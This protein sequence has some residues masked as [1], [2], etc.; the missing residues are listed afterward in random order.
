MGNLIVHIGEMLD[1]GK[2]PTYIA[3]VLQ[4]P[5]SMVYDA[6]ELYPEEGNTEVYSPYV[7]VNS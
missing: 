1:E 6:I 7:T 4:I 3:K 2:H 5:L